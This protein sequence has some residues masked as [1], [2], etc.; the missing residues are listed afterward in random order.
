MSTEVVQ[1]LIQAE[2]SSPPFTQV[3]LSVNAFHALKA[4]ANVA[5]QQ[6]DETISCLHLVYALFNLQP[7]ARSVE[8]EKQFLQGIHDLLELHGVNHHKLDR[9]YK[10]SNAW[11]R[12]HQKQSRLGSVRAFTTRL[13]AS[14]RIACVL[15][16]NSAKDP[17][18]VKTDTILTAILVE[19]TNA[20]SGLLIEV[21][22][23]CL[24]AQVLS[25][26]LNIDIKGVRSDFWIHTCYFTSLPLND[27]TPTKEPLWWTPQLC[28]LSALGVSIDDMNT[29]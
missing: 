1:G 18:T 19:G 21:S 27:V 11:G 2:F 25:S 22:R 28:H 26:Q 13:R 7:E 9:G 14:L 20:A 29:W 4:A 6:G 15:S 16:Q 10:S 12:K 24:T 5:V 8:Q 23:G 17:G 3:E